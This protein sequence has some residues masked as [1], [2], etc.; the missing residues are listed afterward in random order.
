M[1]EFEV[2]RKVKSLREKY[3][4]YLECASQQNFEENRFT[5]FLFLFTSLITIEGF[6]LIFNINSLSGFSLGMIALIPFVVLGILLVLLI[7]SNRNKKEKKQAYNEAEEIGWE[8]VEKDIGA[9]LIEKDSGLFDKFTH[10]V[11]GSRK[12]YKNYWV[13]VDVDSGKVSKTR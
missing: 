6:F 11:M 3:N 10:C 12:G 8:L 4:Q 2:N 13:K 1:E 5:F 9:V 7:P